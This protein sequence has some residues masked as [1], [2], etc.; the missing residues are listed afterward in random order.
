[1]PYVVGDTVE[2]LA[3]FTDRAG[4]A[5]D[6]SAVTGRVRA[7]SGAVTEY[8]TGQFAHPATGAYRLVVAA[9]EGGMWTWRI[10]GTGAVTAA[11]EGQF[12]VAPPTV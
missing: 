9:S 11:E 8:A 3:A 10:A 4:V 1:V 7:P 6:P 5:T 2:L 12:F